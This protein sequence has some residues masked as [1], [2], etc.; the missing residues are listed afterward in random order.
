MLL[1]YLAYSTNFSV[2]FI[3][4]YVMSVRG[5]KY[6]TKPDRSLYQLASLDDDQDHWNNSNKTQQEGEFSK[7]R[8]LSSFPVPKDRFRSF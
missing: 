4:S 7:I 8:L 5:E 3:P 2:I 6:L 1:Q